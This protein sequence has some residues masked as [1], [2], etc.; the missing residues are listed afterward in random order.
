MKRLSQ[1][2]DP[3]ASQ[4]ASGEETSPLDVATLAETFDGLRQSLLLAVDVLERARKVSP[5]TAEIRRRYRRQQQQ[6]GD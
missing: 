4:P 5:T 1:V 6:F 2:A 3:N